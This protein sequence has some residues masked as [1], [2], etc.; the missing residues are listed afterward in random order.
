[1]VARDVGQV[2]DVLRRAD[3]GPDAVLAFPTVQAAVEAVSSPGRLDT[4]RRER[5]ST[6][7]PSG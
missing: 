5:R 6:P 1:V 7:H 2:R 4:G 3:G